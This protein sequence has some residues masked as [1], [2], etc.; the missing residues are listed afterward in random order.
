MKQLF[1]SVSRLW[2][3]LCELDART[4]VRSLPFTTRK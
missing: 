1:Q 2:N 3:A 4:A